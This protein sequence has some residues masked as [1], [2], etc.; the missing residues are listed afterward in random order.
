MKWIFE[1]VID[2][3]TISMETLLIL[4]DECKPIGGNKVNGHD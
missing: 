3:F 2:K 1:N 4:P